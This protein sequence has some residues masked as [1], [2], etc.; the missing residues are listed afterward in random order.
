M[1]DVLGDITVLQSVHIIIGIFTAL[2]GT[3]VVQA[4]E[5]VIWFISHF[6]LLRHIWHRAQRV[7]PHHPHQAQG[8]ADGPSWYL[9]SWPTWY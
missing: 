6:L 2:A 4:G 5:E 1:K 8:Q 7:P 3:W 9:F